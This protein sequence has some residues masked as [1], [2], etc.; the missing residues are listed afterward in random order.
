VYHLTLP[1][2]PTASE[3][4]SHLDDVRAEVRGKVV[5]VGEHVQVGVTMP[6]AA[7]WREDAQLT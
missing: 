3:L 1:T 7:R 5:L 2:R 6:G 4:D